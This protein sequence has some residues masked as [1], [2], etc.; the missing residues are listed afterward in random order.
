MAPEAI[1]LTSD[2]KELLVVLPGEATARCHAK[3]PTGIRGQPLHIA[4]NAT[5]VYVETI[6]PGEYDG[7]I[8]RAPRLLP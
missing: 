5:H 3:L 4:V 2:A 8:V 1:Y 6:V 7:S